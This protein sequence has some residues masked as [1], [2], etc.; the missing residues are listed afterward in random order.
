MH[1]ADINKVD[2]YNDIPVLNC[3]LR[4]RKVASYCFLYVW[5]FV[6]P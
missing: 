3:T 2:S 6:L 5:G 4:K 1:I